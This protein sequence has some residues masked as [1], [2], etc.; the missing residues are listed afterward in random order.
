[1]K[2][3]VRRHKKKIITGHGVIVFALLASSALNFNGGTTTV[4]FMPQGSAKIP[5]GQS[6]SVDININT[7][8]AV[9][10]VG[11]TV[12]YPP[13]MVQIVSISKEKTFLDLWTEDTA[14]REDDGEIHF[15]GGTLKPG[16]LKGTG[17]ILTISLKALKPGTV[18]IFFKDAEIYAHNGTGLVVDRDTRSISYEVTPPTTVSA[19]G[20]VSHQPQPF[21]PS[22]D[23]NG[24]GRITLI[25][26]SILTFR[27]L[28]SYDPRYDLD[29][30][31][32]IGLS[33]I[34]IL[35]SKI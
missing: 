31:G 34:S 8:T 7:E 6:T 5:V 12:K 15:S 23:L 11:A 10:A 27:L 19:P 9:N 33:D 26:V 18:H 35:L 2:H 14:I 4:F 1:M 30:N 32:E 16:G 3:F 17:T 25:D 21:T 20:G 24:D 13:D 28:G 22:S 29:V